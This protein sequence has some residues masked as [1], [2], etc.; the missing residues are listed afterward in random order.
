MGEVYR[1]QDPKLNRLV[2]IKVL[3]ETTAANPVRCE[4]PAGCEGR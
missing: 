2:A 4:N 1:A 3:L